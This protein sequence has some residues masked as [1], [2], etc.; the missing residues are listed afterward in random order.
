MIVNHIII[1]VVKTGIFP[2]GIR[3]WR[4]KAEEE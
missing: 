4:G 2:M 3:Q 1:A